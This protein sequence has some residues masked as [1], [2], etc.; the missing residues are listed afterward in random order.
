MDFLKD[1][2]FVDAAHAALVD[3]ENYVCQGRRAKAQ[4]S[5]LTARYFAAKCEPTD[6]VEDFEERVQEV[7]RKT[8]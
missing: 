5:L 1:L 7:Y 4:D 8:Y 6:L 2:Y 3:A